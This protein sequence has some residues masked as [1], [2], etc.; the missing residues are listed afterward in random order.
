[1]SKTVTDQAVVEFTDYTHSVIEAI[2][3]CSARE[4]LCKQEKILLKPNLVNTTPPPVTTPAEFCGAVVRWLQENTKSEV[5]IA[6]GTGSL[7]YE[8]GH[9]FETLGY[10]DLEK[11]YNIKLMDLN[12]TET[13]LMS[14]PRCTVFKEFHMPLPA[15]EYFIISLPV[16]KAHS[17]AGITGTLKNMMGFAQPQ[18]Y[19]QG[20]MWKKSAFHRKMQESIRDL[21]SYRTPDFTIMD[22]TIGLAEYHLGGTYCNPPPNKI[23]AGFNPVVVDRTAASLLGRDWKRIG[24]LNP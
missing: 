12:H 20:G 14:N 19:Q 11:S 16:L 4:I 9:V 3:A 17:L 13:K 22:A 18:Y 2:E 23:I 5:I 21:N 24:H 1:M 6:E 8:T 10:S 15:L 7:E